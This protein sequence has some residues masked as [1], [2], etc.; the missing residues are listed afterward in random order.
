MGKLKKLFKE[1]RLLMIGICSF[2]VIIAVVLSSYLYIKHIYN[3]NILVDV[4]KVEN[5][6]TVPEINSEPEVTETNY[7]EETDIV[8]VLLVGVD[9]RGEFN[10]SRTDS[11]IIATIDPS[12]KKVKLTSL[13][14]DM[15]VVIPGRGYNKINAAFEIGGIDLLKKTIKYNFGLNVDKNIAI[16]F[17]GF[18]SL[19]D[20]LD[21]VELDVKEYEVKEINKY[22]E[23]VNGANSTLIQSPGM[24]KLDGQQ[25]LS[26]CRIRKVGNNDYERTDRQRRVLSLLLSKVKDT[27][28]LSYPK[29]YSTMSQYVKT[30][31]PF[32]N[33]LKIVYTVYK[34]GDTTTESLR[35]PAD[36]YF[37]DTYINGQS[38]LIPNLKYNATALYKF[39]YNSVPS[40]LKVPDNSAV[41]DKKSEDSQTPNKETTQGNVPKQ[42]PTEP[43]TQTTDSN[44]TK[45]NTQNPDPNN[46]QQNTQNQ[47]PTDNTK[48]NTEGQN[49]SDN[50]NKNTTPSQQTT[51]SNGVNNTAP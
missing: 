43:N 31:I 34:F 21:G 2:I 3:K 14:R 39:I 20:N 13:M 22:I 16:D 30:N 19:I 44:N 15:Y 47:N 17:Q 35:L 4:P 6:N 7:G 45:P 50:S 10:D 23:E 1:K 26:Y 28:V 11:I 42:T 5:D 12:T 9:S 41:Y 38:V 40:N 32:E 48:T 49:P 46:S 8:N 18:Q 25:A 51:N 29:L 33:M 27:S 24:Q 37:K 36:G